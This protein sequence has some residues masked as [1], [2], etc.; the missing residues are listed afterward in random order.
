MKINQMDFRRR[1]IKYKY[2]Y[3]HLKN[4]I[5]KQSGGKVLSIIS[6]SDLQTIFYL[7]F[8]LGCQV[9]FISEDY[10]HNDSTA[11]ELIKNYDEYVNNLENSQNDTSDNEISDNEISDNEISDNEISDN[12]ISDNEISDNEISD[13]SDTSDTSDNEIYDTQENLDVL[14]QLDIDTWKISSEEKPQYYLVKLQNNDDNYLLKIISSDYKYEFIKNMKDYDTEYGKLKTM[15]NLLSAQY[16]FKADNNIILGYVMNFDEN[17]ISLDNYLNNNADDINEK[18][19]LEI[20]DGICK[21]YISVL[22][23]G[24]KPCVKSNDIMVFDLDDKIN[25][26]LTGLD[27][28]TK[29]NSDIEEETVR[30]MV[31]LINVDNLPRELKESYSFKKIFNL[32]DGGLTLKNSIVTVRGLKELIHKLMT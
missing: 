11:I 21:C 20:M 16:L 17:L 23:C 6:K 3:L 32:T 31:K 13:T 25:V 8:E 18:V 9:E 12:E 30:H 28:L 10:K 29:C 2:K 5:Y 26:F 24:M 19:F 27:E 1:Y 15:K 4:I 22:N 7:D 14:Q